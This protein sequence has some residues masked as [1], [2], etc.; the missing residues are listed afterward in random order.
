MLTRCEMYIVSDV[1][2][3]WRETGD[4]VNLVTGDWGI[5]AGMECMV[6]TLQDF[7]NLVRTIQDLQLRFLLY[8]TYNLVHTIKDLW[9]IFLNDIRNSI[10]A[11]YMWM[12]IPF[13]NH[14][15]Y[16]IDFNKIWAIACYRTFGALL[17]LWHLVKKTI[18]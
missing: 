13:L 5:I 7:Y 14:F 6:R 15:Q 16:L 2:A 10:L 8:K 17:N 12:E 3:G 18:I 9:F 11:C 1:D 4:W